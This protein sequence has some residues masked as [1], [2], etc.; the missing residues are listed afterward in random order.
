[1]TEECP[2]HTTI[3]VLIQLPSSGTQRSKGTINQQLAQSFRE[4]SSSSYRPGIKC[5]FRTYE[6]FVSQVDKEE[7]NLLSSLVRF[8]LAYVALND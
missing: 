3:S 7:R 1:M 6:K 8:R 2:T 4:K 5:T